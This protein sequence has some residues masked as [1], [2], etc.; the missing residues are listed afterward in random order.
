MEFIKY[1][2]NR[3][4]FKEISEEQKMLASQLFTADIYF[5][6]SPIIPSHNNFTNVS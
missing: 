3:Q 6:A 4:H 5:N 2:T 1:H